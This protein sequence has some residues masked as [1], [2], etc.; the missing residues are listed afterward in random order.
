LS[1]SVL[2]DD[3]PGDL[4]T[5]IRLATH[6]RGLAQVSIATAHDLRTPLHTVVL[7]LELLRASLTGPPDSETSTKQQRYLDVIASEVQRLEQM[8]EILWAQTRLADSKRERLDLRQALGDLASFLVPHARRTRVDLRL[9][10]EETV[11]IEGDRDALRHAL[12]HMLLVAMAASP[13][14]SELHLTVGTSG[15]SAVLTFAGGD[16]SPLLGIASTDAPPSHHALGPERGLYVSRRVVEGHGGSIKAHAG[17][18]ASSRL[19]VWL[20]LAAAEVE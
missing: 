3:I 18:G 11:A 12:L 15:K 9:D 19:E 17:A 16:L 2:D 4:E 7:Y 6:F 13:V 8:L 1:G 5:D 10:G 14:G 20:P